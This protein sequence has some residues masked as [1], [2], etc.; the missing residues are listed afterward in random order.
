MLDELLLD[1]LKRRAADPARRTD[2]PPSTRGRMVSLGPLSL[3]PASLRGALAGK[4]ETVEEKPE[5]VAAP[6]TD[7]A[8]DAAESS[9]GFELPQ[10]L[11][12][13]LRLIGDGGYGP[14][15]GLMPLAIMVS[16]YREFALAPSDSRQPAW[17]RHMLPISWNDPG[18]ACLDCETGKVMFWDE[19]MLAQS[20]S[21]APHERSFTEIAPTFSAWFAAWVDTLSPEQRAYR[22]MQDAMVNGLRTTIAHWRAKSPDER[23]AFGLP[24]SG[25]EEKLFGHTGIDMRKA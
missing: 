15:A 11:L 9:L 21:G 7:A 23:R 13:V 18:Y 8:L 16:R 19:E 17:P 12:Q 20:E 10:S 14:G 5:P 1:K 2:A 25:W 24:E 6:V 22:M 3:A 4:L